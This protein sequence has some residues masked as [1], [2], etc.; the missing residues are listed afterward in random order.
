MHLATYIAN[1]YCYVIVTPTAVNYSQ[2]GFRSADLRMHKQ[3]SY[4]W[5]SKLVEPESDERDQGR[6]RQ[7]AQQ[8]AALPKSTGVNTNWYTDEVKHLEPEPLC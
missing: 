8:P 3:K 2:I 6:R 7:R 4:T 1:S 5:E